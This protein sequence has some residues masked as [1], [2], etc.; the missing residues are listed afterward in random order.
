MA[1]VSGRTDVQP[2]A[3]PG[4]LASAAHEPVEVADLAAR[5]DSPR[6]SVIVATYNRRE[7][8]KETLLALSRQKAPPFEVIVV[9]DAS[10]DGSFEAIAEMGARLGLAGRVVRLGR[11]Q[12]PAGARNV[13][14]LHAR[15]EVLAF[16][17]SDCLPAEDWIESGLAALAPGVGVVQG[18]TQPLP[19]MPVPFF[20]HFIEA[21]SLDGSFATCN[22][23]YLRRA[24]LD[25]G[26]FDP[27]CRDWEDR[28]LGARVERSGWK[29]RYAGG[30]IVYHQIM[31][32]SPLEWMRWP[33]QLATWPRWVARYP[34]GRR[35]LF[36]RFWVSWDHAAL[37]AALA[38]ILLTPV[39]W[40]ALLLALPY[41]ASFP[42][43]HGWRGRWPLLK[44]GLHLWWDLY[45]WTCLA[46]SSIKHRTLVL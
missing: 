1:V 24:V 15:G 25:A 29:S 31:R 45:G 30:A 20:S 3:L 27:S 38:G 37:T 13:A 12:G 17:D 7:L 5:L 41:A 44:A 36:A 18:R 43:R 28:D 34:E 33:A 32:Q 23:F 22:A 35:F 8:V 21:D 40:P 11:N 42:G 4:H 16:T 9:D 2:E 6:V 26:G 10:T 19:E 14:L 46:V 39:I